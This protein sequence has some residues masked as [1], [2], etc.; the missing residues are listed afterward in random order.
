MLQVLC[1]NNDVV[2]LVNNNNSDP[3]WPTRYTCVASGDYA[4]QA[5]AVNYLY[6]PNIV[7]DI[8][9]KFLFIFLSALYFYYSHSG[10]MSVVVT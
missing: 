4:S 2:L 6:D 1:D 3:K 10:K 8:R 5:L 7:Q 9:K